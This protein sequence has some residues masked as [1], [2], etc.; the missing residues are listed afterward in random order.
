MVIKGGD[1]TGR[2]KTHNLRAERAVRGGSGRF[3]S[4]TMRR[5]SSRRGRRSRSF[6]RRNLGG[7]VSNELG[8]VTSSSSG[9][10]KASSVARSTGVQSI[11]VLQQSMMSNR[12]ISWVKNGLSSSNPICCNVSRVERA[13]PWPHAGPDIF[14]ARITLRS[15]CHVCDEFPMNA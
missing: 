7:G 9:L 3:D 15:M 14:T 10:Q 12:R 11:S 13:C 6:Q 4:P 1:T 2:H 8:Q 5:Q